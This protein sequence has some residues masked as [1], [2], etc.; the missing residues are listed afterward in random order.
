MVELHVCVG[1]SCHVR[2]SY[3]VITTFQRLIEEYKL[4][5]KLELKSSFCMK[6]CQGPV[7][8]SFNDTIYSVAPSGA[9]RFFEETVLPAL[10]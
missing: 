2:G 5:D 7:A 3:N 1:S 8:V 10:N 4:H 9:K 6:N